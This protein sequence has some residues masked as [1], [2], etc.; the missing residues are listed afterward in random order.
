M[1]IR[2]VNTILLVA[3]L[4]TFSLALISCAP[5]KSAPTL[6]ATATT[7]ATDVADRPTTSSVV[8]ADAGT[9][10]ATVP[11]FTDLECLN[12]HTDQARLEELAVPKEHEGEALSSGPG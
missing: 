3:A 6:A 12:C 4:T 8:V 9:P 11:P 10:I 5:D 7:V 1:R 2:V